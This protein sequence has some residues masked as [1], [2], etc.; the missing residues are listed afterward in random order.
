M[1]RWLHVLNQQAEDP[2]FEILVPLENSRLP[3]RY[4]SQFFLFYNIFVLTLVFTYLYFRP[5][6]D[7]T[8]PLIP[9]KKIRPSLLFQPLCDVHYK[10]RGSRSVPGAN[11]DYNNVCFQTL[12]DIFR[13]EKSP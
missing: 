1:V 11:V 9:A 13:L 10:Q 6:R 12:E 4:S 8:F 2:R 5:A 7:V 3:F